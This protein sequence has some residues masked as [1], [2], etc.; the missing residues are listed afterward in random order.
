MISIQLRRFAIAR[1]AETGLSLQE[2]LRSI[3]RAARDG[4]IQF[5]TT[6][7]CTLCGSDKTRIIITRRFENVTTR[8]HKCDFCNNVFRSEEI[9]E[10]KSIQR[11]EN[12]PEPV[13]KKRKKRH[14][15][16]REG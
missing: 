14:I 4:L 12:Q 3:V 10:T 2:I 5:S 13:V 6:N 8:T 15:K 16:D 1:Q 9:R 7:Y 11:L